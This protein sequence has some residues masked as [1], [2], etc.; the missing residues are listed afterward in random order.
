MSQE[1]KKNN[2]GWVKL[3]DEQLEKVTGGKGKLTFGDFF[4]S[5]E[6]EKELANDGTK[7]K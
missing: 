2:E 3:D 5:D 6:F 1:N 4:D 7:K